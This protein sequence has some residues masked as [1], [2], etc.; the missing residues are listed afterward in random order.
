MEDNIQKAAQEFLNKNK[1]SSQP[2]IPDSWMTILHNHGLSDAEIRAILMSTN[3][4][5]REEKA[6][7]VAEQKT[8]DAASALAKHGQHLTNEEIDL[9]KSSYVANLHNEQDWTQDE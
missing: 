5:Y 9:L 3:E 2:T 1:Q 4:I 7:T 6:D 8:L